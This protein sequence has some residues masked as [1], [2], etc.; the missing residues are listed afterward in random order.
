MATSRLAQVLSALSLASAAGIIWYCVNKPPVVEQPTPPPGETPIE[1]SPERVTYERVMLP[2]AV[3]IITCS[4][5]EPS[6][7]PS[8]EKFIT[9]RKGETAYISCSAAIYCARDRC[10]T[11]E[12]DRTIAVQGALEPGE[13]AAPLTEA[14]WIKPG[15]VLKITYPAI[16]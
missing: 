3:F 14:I 15:E 1:E 10:F 13:I 16:F 6:V 12:V 11:I 7:V 2:G 4:P 8:P 5:A 9:I